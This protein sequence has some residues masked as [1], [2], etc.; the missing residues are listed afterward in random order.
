MDSKRKVNGGGH[1]AGD[2]LDDRATK[3]RKVP[4]DNNELLQGETVETTTQYGLKLVE[5]IKK[6][7]DKSGRRIA[8]SFL[9]L[10]DKDKHPE[11]RNVIVMPIA[12]DT[13]QAK[14]ERGEFKT[15]TDL[16]SYF[17]RMISNAKEYNQ[18][19]SEIYDDAERLRK[20]LSNFMTKTNPAYKNVPGYVA[21]PTPLPTK[22]VDVQE[23]EDEDAEGEPDSEAEKAAIAKRSRG[24]PPK[25]TKPQA[26]VKSATP[27]AT[28]SR[29]SRARFAKLNFQQAQEK[30]LEELIQAKEYPERVKSRSGGKEASTEF[31]TWAAFE[32]EMG[33]I[34]SNAWQYNEDKSQISALAKDLKNHFN[35]LLKEAKQAV[36]E[37]TPKIHLKVNNNSEQK[38]ITLKFGNRGSPAES[39]APQVNGSSG[40]PANGTRRNPFGG[41]NTSIAPVPSL[42]QL[43]R[44]RS[45]S[46]S[47]PSP[48]TS[49]SA[50]VKNEE[51]R[52]SPAV[53]APIQ[54][55]YRGTSQT[56]S[57][58][59]LPTSG[60]LPPSTPGISNHN[61]YTAGGYAQSFPHPHQP[62]FH[63]QNPAFESKWRQPGKSASDAMITNLSLATH[64]GLNISRHFKMDLPPS[65]TM[66]QQSI[67]INLP[68]THYFLQIKPTIATA[69]LDR[70][71]KL[72]VTTNMSRLNAIPTIPG[73]NV[74][75][76]NP[77]FETRINPGVNRIEVELIAAL[78]KG[79]HKSASGQEVELEK[80]TIFANLLRDPEHR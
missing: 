41:S 70:Q 48:T 18:K 73:H 28:E 78:P 19:G 37:P 29:N 42:D 39:P 58:P 47:A 1:A 12:L 60:M 30:I 57:T 9:T 31:K 54:S 11:Y 40:T 65:P 52:N 13:I 17:K 75:Q 62:Q 77:L 64:P 72:F 55:N 20:A 76:R 23:E 51:A 7:E 5:I 80:I 34:W 15:L 10:P 35:K 32:K 8:T 21:A 44:A 3:R 71:Y 43:E 14:L 2:E 4:A 68:H 66:A 67:T 56:V 36:Q 45:A 69:V 26:P 46:G 22:K 25:S 38:K 79:A 24:R 59:G 16:E 61:M 6:T 53:P 74:D 63:V 33:L 50:V 27:A 49:N